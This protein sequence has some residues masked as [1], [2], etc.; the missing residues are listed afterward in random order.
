MSLFNS[1]VSEQ[2]VESRLTSPLTR[3]SRGPEQ[4][5][6]VRA[7]RKQSIPA[8]LKDYDLSDFRGT[9]QEDQS[10]TSPQL[11]QQVKMNSADSARDVSIKQEEPEDHP[12]LSTYFN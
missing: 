8:R 11:L 4:H 6:S 1:F 5:G 3:M 12:Q 10:E 9:S 2:C 7:R